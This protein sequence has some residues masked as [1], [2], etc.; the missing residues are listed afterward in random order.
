M[1]E[2]HEGEASPYDI[3]V[4]ESTPPVPLRMATAIAASVVALI[5]SIWFLQQMQVVAIPVFV[6]VFGALVMRPLQA[7]IQRRIPK[8]MGGLGTMVAALIPVTIL[9]G[10]ATGIVAVL[11]A[12]APSR[13]EFEEYWT[14][15]HGWASDQAGKVG[16]ELPE[17]SDVGSEALASIGGTLSSM[18]VVFT[19]IVL[20][21][22][23][24]LLLLGEA[25]AMIRRATT[26]LPGSI[27]VRVVEASKTIGMKIRQFLLMR[28]IVGLI[29]GVLTFILL[30][31]L[32]VDYALLWAFLVVLFNYIPNV[33]ALLGAVAPILIATVQHDPLRGLGVAI[34][35][36][37]I[38]Q[39]VGSFLAPKLQGA[40]L[41]LSPFLVL[42]S[43][44]FFSWM[45]GIGGMLIATPCLLLLVIVLEEIPPLAPI[46][47][48][49]RRDADSKR[50]VDDVDVDQEELASKT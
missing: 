12:I 3:A 40:R 36:F 32:G 18:V 46:A 24:M 25:D 28:T 44:V 49:M 2:E 29:S 47:A 5:A 33:G 39:V 1:S 6:A 7:G 30:F 15:V 19:G 37:L 11:V 31:A 8:W 43:L 41:R 14:K 23:F 9:I 50:L 17:A 20:T 38:E 34:G 16:M 26:N 4:S 45:W 22:I 42:A 13:A 35:M 10:T 21:T 48:L 27:A